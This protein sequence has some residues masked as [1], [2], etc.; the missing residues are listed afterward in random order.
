MVGNRESNFILSKPLC[1]LFTFQLRNE[2]SSVEL[3]NRELLSRV[4]G[5]AAA[6][7]KVD[8]CKYMSKLM[9]F[10]Y[11]LHRLRLS[12][13]KSPQSLNCLFTQ[14]IIVR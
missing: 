6:H 12:I 4:T 9:R 2:M 5:L 11:L 10:Q 1:N 3:T 8:V 14:I 13:D 7:E